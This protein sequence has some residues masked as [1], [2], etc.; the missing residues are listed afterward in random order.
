MEMHHV[1]VRHDPMHRRHRV[2]RETVQ[3]SAHRRQFH[4]PGPIRFAGLLQPLGRHIADDRRREGGLVPP[5]LHGGDLVDD[6]RGGPPFRK[7]IA[8]M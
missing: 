1:V 5:G 7:S 6:A 2:L 8:C 4:D 3:G